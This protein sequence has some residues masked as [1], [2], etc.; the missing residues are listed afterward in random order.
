MKLRIVH[1][2]WL[3]RPYVL[4]EREFIGT[5]QDEDGHE[6]PQ[7]GIWKATGLNAMNETEARALVERS[8]T[9]RVIAEFDIG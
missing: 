1:R 4:E 9:E 3:A 6:V 2:P 8:K 5:Q 7:Y